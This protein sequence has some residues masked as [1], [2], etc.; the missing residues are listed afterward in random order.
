MGQP[1]SRVEKGQAPLLMWRYH[2]TSGP[3]A[4]SRTW[5]PDH[6][7]IKPRSKPLHKQRTR[8]CMACPSPSR[9]CQHGSYQQNEQPFNQ[10]MHA[11][12][13]LAATCILPSRFPVLDSRTCTQEIGHSIESM[14]GPA[15][16]CVTST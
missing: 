7:R 6:V 11:A 10:A 4:S 3:G 15:V 9:G 1:W 14:Q 16:T 12:P 5:A 13:C 2:F 8:Q